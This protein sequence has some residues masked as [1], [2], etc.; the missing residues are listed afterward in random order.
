[1]KNIPNFIILT[2][3]TINLIGCGSNDGGIKATSVTLKSIDAS[4]QDI[5][6]FFTHGTTFE[7]ELTFSDNGKV[8]GSVPVNITPKALGAD[9]E[10]VFDTSNE[11]FAFG[12]YAGKH[13]NNLMGYYKGIQ[14]HAA[15]YKG[16]KVGQLYNGKGIALTMN[17]IQSSGLGVGVGF[18][19]ITVSKR[20]EG[21]LD[22]NEKL[23]N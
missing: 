10:L 19:Y 23:K 5:G 17:Y 6:F 16:V 12:G 2:L 11:I 21:S 13:I 22:W 8:Q 1:M 15:V 3:F 18:P 7:G 4:G 14:L 20:G 9:V